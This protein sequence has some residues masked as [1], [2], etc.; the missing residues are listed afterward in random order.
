M[1]A[2]QHLISNDGEHMLGHLIA[3]RSEVNKGS[4]P[5]HSLSSAGR[6]N[7]YQSGNNL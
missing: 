7:A 2:Q 6:T 3:A 4:L 5:R 1:Y